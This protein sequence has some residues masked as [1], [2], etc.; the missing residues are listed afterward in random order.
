MA[1]HM[2]WSVGAPGDLVSLVADHDGIRPGW[3]RMRLADEGLWTEK[4]F[5]VKEARDLWWALGQACDLV[6]SQ[7]DE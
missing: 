4:D 1:A 5:T 2:T 7:E 3:I 6:E